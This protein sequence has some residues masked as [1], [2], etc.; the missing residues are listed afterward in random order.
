MRQHINS[1]LKVWPAA[2]PIPQDC[3]EEALQ[4]TAW[5]RSQHCLLLQETSAE[6]LQTIAGIALAAL[7]DKKASVP[8]ALLQTAVLLHDTALLV[9]AFSCSRLPL[10]HLAASV[11]L[12]H[13]KPV[14]IQPLAGR[15]AY[16]YN[17]FHQYGRTNVLVRRTGGEIEILSY[18]AAESGPTFAG[19]SRMAGA[20]GERGKALCCLVAD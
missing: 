19:G 8:D 18:V 20:A 15:L 5:A 10:T 3:E 14:H 1:P 11:C 6:A 2:Q 16:A 17:S 4:T 7:A 13:S 9:S 12:M